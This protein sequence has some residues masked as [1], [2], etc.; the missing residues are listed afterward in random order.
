MREYGAKWSLQGN[1]RPDY[2]T[3]PHDE[4]AVKANQFFNEI[5]PVSADLRAGWIC[6]LGHGVISD[7]ERKAVLVD[8]VV[9][10]NTPRPI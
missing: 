6:G 1:F 4:F 3:L 7:A 9:E 8:N 2:L 10:L 5:A